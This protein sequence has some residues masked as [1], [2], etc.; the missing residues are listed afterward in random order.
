[1]KYRSGYVN[2]H[3]NGIQQHQQQQT[4]CDKNVAA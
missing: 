1:M 4:E 2:E 3:S